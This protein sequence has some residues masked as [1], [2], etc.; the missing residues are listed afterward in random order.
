[1]FLTMKVAFRN[2]L[3]QKK[4]SFLLA[5][6]IG[7]G[8]LVITLMNALTGGVVG[9]IRENFSHALGGHVFIMGRE[10]TD[11]GQMIMKIR[12]DERLDQ[13][14][15]ENAGQIEALTRRSQAMPTMIFGSRQT[16][17]MLY[18][19]DFSEENKLLDSLVVTEG[20]FDDVSVDDA[21]IILPQPIGERL[22]VQVGETL[23]IRLE[24]LT[25]QQNV[26][27]VKVVAFIEDQEELGLSAA[28]TSRAYLNAL[29]GM[30][31]HEYQLLNM[32][33]TDLDLVDDFAR[34][35]REG[36]R[37][38]EE[39]VE[40]VVEAEPAVSVTIAGMPLDSFAEQ[41]EI[42]PWEGTRYQI[43]HI[44]QI[45]EAVELVV[46]VLNQVGQV[47]FLIL[48]VVTMVGITNTFR[49]MMIERTK[50]IGTM[51]AFGMHQKRVKNIFLWEAAFLG[52]L[53]CIA[54]LILA[55]IVAVAVGSIHFNAD[56]SMQFFL[57]TGKITFVF[58]ITNVIINT[59]IVVLISLIAAYWPARSAA[60]MSPMKALSSHT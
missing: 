41:E 28:Y 43:M 32:F 8:M 33:L 5:G 56:P 50:E 25:G 2:V 18:G 15:E 14:L 55:G 31:L 4:R 60:K 23:L 12:P 21:S 27:E 26:G 24:T 9:N 30:E 46:G 58:S 44:N 3:R 29:L 54:G 1:M 42:T 47:I 45:M 22:G 35:V 19:V 10:W 48:L 52:L 6:A 37:A 49:M 7:F 38:P 40:E 59:A 17:Q 34:I 51:R 53:G 16:M 57:D 36:L 11:A 13:L 39:E 20:S